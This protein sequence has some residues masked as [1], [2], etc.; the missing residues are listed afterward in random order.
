LGSVWETAMKAA[1]TKQMAP[2]LDRNLA[3]SIELTGGP[4]SRLAS[5]DRDFRTRL[6][7]DCYT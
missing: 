3:W 5:A 6:S 7:K 4:R 1:R 2:D